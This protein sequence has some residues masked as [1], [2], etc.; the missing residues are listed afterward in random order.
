MGVYTYINKD[1]KR[2][3]AGAVPEMFWAR[4]RCALDG[5]ARL[6]YTG[7]GDPKRMAS[8]C[9]GLFPRPFS[10]LRGLSL[11]GPSR[12]VGES[13]S[14]NLRD[15]HYLLVFVLHEQSDPISY[16]IER[17]EQSLRDKSLPDIPLHS[18][19]LLT[20]HEGYEDMPLAGRRRLLSSFRVLFRNLPVRHACVALRLSE[21]GNIGHVEAAMR[22]SIANFLFDNLG[23]FQGFDDVKIYYD[24]GQ[25]TIAHA[26]HRAMDFALAKNAVVYRAAV[27]ENYRL[28]QAA[29]YICTMELVALRYRDG[30]PSATDEKFFG[31]WSQFKKG[32]LREMRAKR[33]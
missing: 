10:Y 28:S 16:E 31:S 5:V 27:P 29:D 19:P 20:G 6:W 30:E 23:Y 9:R 1:A 24:N 17:Y 21:Y 12:P 13:G 8:K 22:R 26:L 15:E 32:I 3:A 25:R 4:G 18:G 7:I 14:D 33:V 2:G 11:R